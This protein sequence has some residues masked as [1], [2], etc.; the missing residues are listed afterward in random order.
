MK[1]A[2]TKILI[3]L[4]TVLFLAGCVQTIPKDALV[5]GEKNLQL[6]QLQTK[7]FTTSNEKSLLSASAQVL[8]DMGF[9]IDESEMKLGL[10]AASKDASAVNG[11]QIAAAI[12]VAALGGGSMPIDKNQKIRVSV[13]TKS[14]SEKTTSL[15]AT[16]QRIVWDTNGQISHLDVLTDQE[17]YKDFFSKLSK[18]V[19][20]TANEI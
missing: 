18:S 17:I 9:T 7:K 13:V 15:R 16:F 2:S 19:F 12:L 3:T 11:G 10:I 20:L 4:L 5:L 6:R 14:L 1:N 8:Q